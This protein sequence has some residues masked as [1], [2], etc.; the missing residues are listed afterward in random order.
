MFSRQWVWGR[1]MHRNRERRRLESID[2]M[3]A[4]AIALVRPCQELPLVFIR[5]AVRTFRAR[6]VD[7]EV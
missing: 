4:L 7:A 3:A 5:M 6:Y 1:L 2:G